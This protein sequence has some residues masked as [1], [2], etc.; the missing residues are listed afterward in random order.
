MIS[1]NLNK[2]KKFVL[3]SHNELPE[4]QQPVFEIK[5]LSARQFSEVTKLALNVGENN[6]SDVETY[7]ASFVE[8][9]KRGINSKPEL[10]EKLPDVLTFAEMY[11]LVEEI[12]NY[13][14]VGKKA[15]KN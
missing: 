15:A 4:H 2:T 7:I 5:T 13:N 8:I 10:I 14:S 11:E 3:S 12:I 1:V 6:K 9:C